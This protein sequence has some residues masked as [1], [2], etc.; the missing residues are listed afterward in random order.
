[1][2]INEAAILICLLVE[3]SHGWQAKVSEIMTKFRKVFLAQHL[4][5]SLIR[6]PRHA[7][8]FYYFRLVFAIC[9]IRSACRSYRW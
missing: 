2:A 6:T 3:V 1:M 5:F 4:R 7:G 9:I 8:G